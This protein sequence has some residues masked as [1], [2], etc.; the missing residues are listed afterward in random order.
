MRFHSGIHSQQ[1]HPRL[2]AFWTGKIGRMKRDGIWCFTPV[3]RYQSRIM[4][5]ST[6]GQHQ[7]WLGIAKGIDVRIALDIVRLAYRREL[8]VALIFSQDQ[9]LAKAAL[10]LRQ[11]AMEQR[12]WIKAV[13][14][15]PASPSYANTRG[16]NGTDWLRIT[17][18]VYDAC[19]D[20]H[21]YWPIRP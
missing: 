12:R 3:V 5:D 10:E 16:I 9:D 7:R 1:Q 18:E 20:G 15:F 4:R 2:H 8:D 13:S 19:L 17:G 14:A 11:I 21:D 6:G